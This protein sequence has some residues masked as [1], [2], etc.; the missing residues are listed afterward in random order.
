MPPRP[1][2]R[3]G[4]CSSMAEFCCPL[5]DLNLQR[6]S[7]P[8]HLRTSQWPR[9]RLAGRRRARPRDGPARGRSGRKE[10]APTALEPETIACM[11]TSCCSGGRR[12]RAA[13][14][15]RPPVRLPASPTAAGPGHCRTAW[16]RAVSQAGLGGPR[17]GL[18]R[19]QSARGAQR[20]SHPANGGAASGRLACGRQRGALSATPPAAG[21]GPG[22]V[23][24]LFA[25]PG[26]LDIPGAAARASAA[27]LAAPRAGSRCPCP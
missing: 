5:G 1:R 13:A 8:P 6:D 2:P 26:A 16:P 19:T 12:G 27:G 4:K 15:T 14:V 17:L 20:R 21:K 18:R 7:E 23:P 10:T 25:A 22:A 24:G 9:P 11:A 3:Q